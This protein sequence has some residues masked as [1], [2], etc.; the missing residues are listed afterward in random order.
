MYDGG[1]DGVFTIASTLLAVLDHWADVDQAHGP[2]LEAIAA[3]TDEMVSLKEK[4]GEQGKL[5]GIFD[6]RERERT[7]HPWSR[8]KE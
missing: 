2:L 5:Y 7:Y 4:A 1:E 8:G 6:S 3:V